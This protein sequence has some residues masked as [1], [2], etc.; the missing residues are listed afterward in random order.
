M[1]DMTG[2]RIPIDDMVAHAFRLAA[3]QLH[4][5][6][7][8][9]RLLSIAQQI[10]TQLHGEQCPLCQRATCYYECPLTESRRDRRKLMER[11]D[12]D[13]AANGLPPL[14]GIS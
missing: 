7:D 8:R 4:D 5:E 13:R 11:I 10:D 1:R 6:T 9:E 3:K 14:D 2:T 12:T